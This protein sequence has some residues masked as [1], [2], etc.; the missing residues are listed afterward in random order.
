MDNKTLFIAIGSFLAGAGIGSVA[1]YFYIK[2]KTEDYIN[3][4]LHKTRESS[5]HMYDS[6]KKSSNELVSHIKEDVR[7]IKNDLNEEEPEEITEFQKA[8]PKKPPVK[9]P[10]KIHN[11]FK[12]PPKVNENEPEI[13]PYKTYDD[14]IKEGEPNYPK[15]NDIGEGSD[16]QLDQMEQAEKDK[17]PVP[18]GYTYEEIYGSNDPDKDLEERENELS[19]EEQNELDQIEN[20]ELVSEELNSDNKPDPYIISKEEFIHGPKE[21]YDQELLDYYTADKVLAEDNENIIDEE[22]QIKY[23]IGDAYK[24]F[25]QDSEDNLC[26]Y[27]RNEYLAMEYE[28]H[29]IIGSYQDI[30]INQRG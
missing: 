14:F 12:E 23:V 21:G 1:T 5:N 4:E 3:E 17:K 8:I 7:T 26:V 20:D 6:V 25:G 13:H 9:Q 22:E 11:I 19:E 16:E 29:K 27:V 28:V 10:R 30:I 15:E 24:H 18:A 2:N